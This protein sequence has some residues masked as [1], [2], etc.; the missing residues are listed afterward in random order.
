MRNK[1]WFHHLAGLI[2]L[3]AALCT[4]QAWWPAPQSPAPFAVQGEISHIEYTDE[5]GTEVVL[6]Y[7]AAGWQWPQDASLAINQNYPATMTAKLAAPAAQYLT[8]AAGADM[9]LY[10]LQP[11]GK[12]I[13]FSTTEGDMVTLYLG[14]YNSATGRYYLLPAEGDAVYTVDATFFRIFTHTLLDIAVVPTLWEAQ[15]A[16]LLTVTAADTAQRHTLQLQRGANGQWTAQDEQVAAAPAQLSA[17]HGYLQE[18]LGLRAVSIALWKP[19]PRELLEAGADGT[20]TLCVEYR[21]DGRLYEQTL[22]VGAATAGSTTLVYLQ[23][24]PCAV[25][26]DTASLQTLLTAQA[27]TL[28]D[29]PLPVPTE[30][31]VTAM[32][33]RWPEGETLLT[34]QAGDAEHPRYF[35]DG[36]AISA[37]Q[38]HDLYYHLYTLSAQDRIPWPETGLANDAVP[39]FTIRF[40]LCG[41][42]PEQELQ[43]FSYDTQYYLLQD[44]SGALLVPR[45]ALDMALGFAAA[46][47]D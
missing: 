46:P 16:E 39:A 31:S 18:L 45:A 17:V 22:L 6:D 13:C 29:L 35:Q 9:T 38:F 12:T 32:L 42:Q 26:A 41:A 30:D 21:R 7:T 47:S 34:I 3:L 19:T 11:A 23:D 4:L 36:A 8:P 2:A 24:A 28:R 43:F 1:Q 37:Q 40:T 27:Q 25:W 14:A 15:A 33:L 5:T 10:G 20:R 44:E